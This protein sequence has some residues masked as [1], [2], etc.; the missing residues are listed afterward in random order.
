MAS[1]Q[2]E[3]VWLT[4]RKIILGRGKGTWRIREKGNP[5]VAIYSNA[6]A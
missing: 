1:T 2:V 5:P 3:E 6:L 4:T